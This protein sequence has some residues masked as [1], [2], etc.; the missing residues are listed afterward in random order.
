V[1]IY[2]LFVK[3]CVLAQDIFAVPDYTRYFK[4]FTKIRRA[5]KQYEEKVW[6]QLQ[7]IIEA[8]ETCEEFPLGVRTFYRA[9]AQ[10]EAIEIC[11]K[12]NVIT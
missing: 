5:F 6:S 12:E 3:F 2:D 4:Q 11:P 10:N 1:G 9:Y 8:T 7:F